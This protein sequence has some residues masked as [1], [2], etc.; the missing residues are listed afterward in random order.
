M[1]KVIGDAGSTGLGLLETMAG[2]GGE[3]LGFGLDGTV[4]LSPAG[5]AVNI[6]SAALIAHGYSTGV[7]AGMNLQQDAKDLYNQFSSEGGSTKGTGEAEFKT[8]DL[9]DEHFEKHVVKQGEFGNITKEQYLKGAQDLI[10]SKPGGDILTKTRINGDTVFYNKET[11]EFAI[12]TRDGT[13][14]TYFK[15]SDGLEYFNRQ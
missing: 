15:P 3:V 6:G 9:L 5:V 12:R 7:A 13:I 1:G 8:Q 10:N 11:N 4:V 14:R 2:G